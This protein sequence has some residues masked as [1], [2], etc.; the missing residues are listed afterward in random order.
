MTQNNVSIHFMIVTWGEVYTHRLIKF[1]LPSLLSPRNLPCIDNTHNVFTIATTKK[2]RK[3][4]EKSG[5]YG[6]LKK[7]INVSFV[8]IDT[9]L[10]EE[11][12]HHKA[13]RAQPKFQKMT[14]AHNMMIERTKELNMA[15]SFIMPDNIFFDGALS[16]ALSLVG[17]KTRLVYVYGL[18]VCEEKINP[19]LESYFS[20]TKEVL[21]IGTFDL[22][23]KAVQ[24]LHHASS[25]S[26]VDA[27]PFLPNGNLFFKF[28]T[29]LVIKLCYLHPLVVYPK[30]K[31]TMIPID[32]TFDDGDY[33]NGIEEESI[34]YML[35]S[36]DCFMYSLDSN[37][38][39]NDLQ[40]YYVHKFNIFEQASRIK[41]MDRCYLNHLKKESILY[42][43]KEPFPHEKK[44]KIEELTQFLFFLLEHEVFIP[45]IQSIKVA[46]LTH[47]LPQEI[48][49]QTKKQLLNLLAMFFEHAHK[50][51]LDTKEFKKAHGLIVRH[52]CKENASA[53]EVLQSIEY[54]FDILNNHQ[55]TELFGILQLKEKVTKTKE[56]LNKHAEVFLYG[57]GEDTQILLSLLPDRDKIV[58]IFDDSSTKLGTKILGIKVI[59]PLFRPDEFYKV[60][61]SSTLYED[62]IAQK[63]RGFENIKI[64]TLNQDQK[65]CQ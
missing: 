11:E 18:H 39:K 50:Y 63:I 24:S 12:Q 6:A 8:P 40:K 31:G 36:R 30:T 37:R 48:F 65:V 3:L 57:A 5:V 56:I 28:D 33:L 43:T 4:I 27:T 59:K 34:V 20:P 46:C 22:A 61:I 35:D 29:H 26:F 52:T 14:K 45:N 16:H 10:K 60:I 41:N 47:S 21:E 7:I 17:E 42:T 58:A 25:S 1:C 23:H 13:F 51:H 32:S 15:Y 49:Y 64:Y 53:L 9:M 55:K 44:G 54:L 62:A 2:D 38:Q 19:L